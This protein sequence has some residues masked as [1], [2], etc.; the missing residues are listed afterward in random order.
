MGEGKE[1]RWKRQGHTH[2]SRTRNV[3]MRAHARTTAS[4]QA[5]KRERSGEVA[6]NSRQHEEEGNTL[7]DRSERSER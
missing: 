2:N 5:G 4:K 6:R 1:R 7:S 3:K